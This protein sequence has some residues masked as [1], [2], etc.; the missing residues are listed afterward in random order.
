MSP[1][2][3][4]VVQCMGIQILEIKKV[5][6]DTHF[7]FVSSPGF[8]GLIPLSVHDLSSDGLPLLDQLCSL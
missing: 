1:L 7:S 5:T 2:F 6:V 8:K 4:D 3:S